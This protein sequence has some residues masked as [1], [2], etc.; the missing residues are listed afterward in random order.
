MAL[1]ILFVD[2][3]INIL[4][5]LKRS[6]R[7]VRR[8]YDMHFVQGG[9]EALSL[10]EQSGQ[11][12]HM[13]VSDL[14]MPGMDGTE[15]LREV[16]TRYPHMFR[17]ALS[18]GAETETMYET[19]RLA[20]QYLSKP[21]DAD[22]LKET[23]MGAAVLWNLLDDGPLKKLLTHLNSIPSMPRAYQQILVELRRDEA[24]LKR[25]GEIVRQDLGM[26]VKML[27]LVNS[28]FF[29]V[30]HKVTRPDQAATLLGLETIKALVL[31]IGIFNT[32]E[33]DLM[34]EF[35]HDSFIQHGISVGNLAKA[36]VKA[37]GGNKNM[38]DEAFTA[39]MLHDAGKL[40][41]AAHLPVRYREA[42]EMRK[43]FNLL[44]SDAEKQMVGATH[45]EAGAFLLGIWGLPHAVVEAIAFHHQPSASPRREFG[46]LAALHAADMLLQ[47]CTK[48]HG[49]RD[50]AQLDVGYYDSLGLSGAVAQWKKICIDL[51]NKETDTDG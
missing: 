10:L 8:D 1:R 11:P 22:I 25:I 19:S 39:G 46:P 33:P 31:S 6:L 13:I 7:S 32:F 9:P 28:A 44:L 14:R 23:I 40:L 42:M 27:Q 12:F 5:G 41:L 48:V 15:L 20:H 45:A 34:P 51:F 21:C 2:D 3:D 24:S 38:Q 30:A 29:G 16:R 18:G 26:T 17:Y 37:Q 43:R 49:M 36:I 47:E 50:D 35:G 4:Q